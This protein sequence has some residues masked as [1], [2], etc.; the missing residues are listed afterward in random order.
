MKFAV[1]LQ[2]QWR[3]MGADVAIDQ[4]ELTT[5]GDRL[6]QRKFDAMLNAWQIDPDPASVRDEWTSREIRKGGSN[7]VSYNNPVF[8]ATVDS[9][10]RES[11]P[12]R[13]A[14]LYRR[15]YRQLTEDAPALWLY[16][17]RNVFG[18]SQRL[19]PVGIRADAWWADLAE[20]RVR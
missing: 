9:A 8:D 17:L 16:E 2:D 13:A 6:E 12:A 10:A 7:F 18:I 11:N 3:R 5:F 19:H 20:W 14:A 1:L 15:A 4:M